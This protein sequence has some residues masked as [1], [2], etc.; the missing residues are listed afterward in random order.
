MCITETNLLVQLK[1]LE[2]CIVCVLWTV[3]SETTYH[4]PKHIHVVHAHIIAFHHT[5]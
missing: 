3:L 1:Y 2:I 5:M 4:V